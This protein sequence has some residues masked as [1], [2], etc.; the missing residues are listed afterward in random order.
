MICCQQDQHLDH[1]IT[2]VMTAPQ[3]RSDQQKHKVM[4]VRTSLCIT[5][6]EQKRAA[7]EKHYTINTAFLLLENFDDKK[8]S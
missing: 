7:F 6:Q 3:A 1:P 5:G 2:P 8:S 4:S